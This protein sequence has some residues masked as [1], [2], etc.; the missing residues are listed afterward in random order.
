MTDEFV[1][2]AAAS[3]GIAMQPEWAPEVR[4]H[5]E[6]MLRMAEMVLA[7]ELPDEAEP[8]LVFRA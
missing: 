2:E 5:L 4:A 6:L 1:T 3:L 7:F 8:A